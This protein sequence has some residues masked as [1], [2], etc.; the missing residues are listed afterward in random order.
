MTIRALVLVSIVA[1]PTV[2]L[3]QTFEYFGE[4]GPASGISGRS[5]RRP[6]PRV[7]NGW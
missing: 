4:N 3:A 2:S 6:V 7:S 1:T 5:R